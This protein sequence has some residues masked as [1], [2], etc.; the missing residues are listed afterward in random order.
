MKYDIPIPYERLIYFQ[1]LLGLEEREA[2]TLERYQGF[3]L[4]KSQEFAEHCYHYFHKIPETR[5]ILEH[6]ERSGN[7]KRIWQHWFESLFKHKLDR[8]LLPYLWRSG[9]R[10]VELNIDQRFVNLGYSIVRRFCQRIA[11]EVIPTAD[12]EPV[13]VAID[14]MLDNCLLIETQAFISATSQCDIKVVRGISHQ[15]RNPITII[16]GNISR[17]QKKVKPGD[18]LYHTYEIIMQENKRLERMAI[19]AGVYSEMFQKDPRFSNNSLKG[20]IS[21]ALDRL[22]KTDWF[23]NLRIHTDLD[24]K[25]P[26]IQGDPKDLETMFYYLLQNSIEALNPDNPHIRIS[27]KMK[28][29]PS[30]FIEI[31]IFNTG[32]PPKPEELSNLFVP[33]YSSKPYGTGFGLP[34][35]QLAARKDLGEIYLEALADQGTKCIVKLPIPARKT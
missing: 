32:T 26:E 9:L 10:H 14:K 8:Q 13:L 1:E 3:F 29:P 35:A 16:G 6:E 23:K 25:F 20:L 22:R 2:P 12:L 5:I 18:S 4:E 28:D 21:R 24:P 15:V 19:D 7:M 27:S 33:F 11:R 34:I 30:P 31:E 17:L